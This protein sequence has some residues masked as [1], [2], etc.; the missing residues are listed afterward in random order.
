MGD[1]CF[2]RSRGQPTRPTCH[3]STSRTG[4][5]STAI[6]LSTSAFPNGLGNILVPIRAHGRWRTNAYIYWTQGR[7]GGSNFLEEGLA[8][9]FQDEPAYHGNA[10]QRYIARN[11]LHPHNYAEGKRL[12]LLC[13]PQLQEAV[14]T[15]R[16][17]GIRI[18]DITTN[19]LAEQ[20]EGVDR[21]TVERLCT[22]FEY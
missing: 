7:G 9:W 16:S 1:F 2:A 21:A 11:P 22:R 3:T 14:R 15:I 12:V 10:V 18:G 5:I 6:V 20:L 19:G 17:S 4:F 13:M 8:T